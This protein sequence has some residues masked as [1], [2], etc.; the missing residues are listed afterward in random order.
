MSYN[1]NWD[2]DPNYAETNEYT[3]LDE[4]NYRVSITKAIPTTART[5]SEGLEITLAVNGYNHTIRH[6]IWLDFNNVQRTNQQLG[7]FF[8]SFD[9]PQNE[10]RSCE[11]W[12]GRTGAVRVIHSNYKGRT[13]AKVA[14]CISRD[15]QDK[16]PAWR[17][18]VYSTSTYQKSAPSPSF[19]SAPAMPNEYA[20]PAPPQTQKTFN[21]FNVF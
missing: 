16:L 13:I 7:E 11:H 18:P 1:F 21:G 15:D 10:Q 14:F 6:F 2:Y 5:G 9:I 19:N 17:E 12:A 20:P 8:N 3:L 4:G